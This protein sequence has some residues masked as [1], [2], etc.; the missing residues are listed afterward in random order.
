[1]YNA[2]SKVSTDPPPGSYSIRYRKRDIWEQ[3]V[4]TFKTSTTSFRYYVS[5][6]D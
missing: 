4:R 6:N 3:E 2:S 1:M 5:E